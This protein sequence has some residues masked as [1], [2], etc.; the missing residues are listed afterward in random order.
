MAGEPQ[1]EQTAQTPAPSEAPV[2]G[3]INTVRKAIEEAKAKPVKTVEPKEEPAK[4]EP[5]KEAEPAKSEAEEKPEDLQQKYS[6]L[7]GVLKKTQ[8]ELA[9]IKGEKGESARLAA[10][11]EALNLRVTDL[12]AAQIDALAGT[13]EVTAETQAKRQFDLQMAGLNI[14]P[15]HPMKPSVD[16]LQAEVSSGS[17]PAITGMKLLNKI[18]QPS[19]SGTKKAAPA[20]E[21]S[22]PESESA[23]PQEGLTAE[24]VV[25]KALQSDTLTVV[26]DRIAEEVKKKLN[27]DGRYA[28]S[29]GGTSSAGTGVPTKN[30]AIREWIDDTREKKG[31]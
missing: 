22:P 3:D 8:E 10:Q 31:G 7:Q 19:L 27:L 21:A 16:A 11:V 12:M 29:R 26:T 6:S 28:A 24:A 18:L 15:D 25:E 23:K 20:T 17:M 4:G 2:V 5:P 13:D 9:A 1:V 14:A 30:E